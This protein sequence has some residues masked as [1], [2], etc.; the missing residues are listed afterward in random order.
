MSTRHTDQWGQT[1]RAYLETLRSGSLGTNRRGH[2]VAGLLLPRIAN[3]LRLVAVSLAFALPLGVVKGVRD[4]QALRRRGSAVGPL[5]TGLLQGVPDFFLVMLLQIGAAQFFQRTGFRLLPVAW[6]ETRPV[7][8]MVLPVT[9]LALLPLATVA[10]I[11]T[12]AMTNVY[13]QD[14]IRTARAKGLPERVV[15]YKHA[16]AGAL[17]P[18][19]DAMPGVLTVAFSNALIAERLFHYPGVTNLLLDA[20]SPPSLV[21]D[22]R[23][24]LPPPDV[25]VLV[26][27]GAS[28][29][30]IFALLY[31]GVSIL[32]R[33]A[34][35]RL[36]GRDLP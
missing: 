26:A 11:T 27:A 3:T 4:F 5:L 25:P 18:I 9:C 8:S 21:F 13:E 2:D 19:L 22:L 24:P 35:P 7:A 16:L 10:R 17:V 28:L 36:K 1:L 29:G 32:R 6:D 14:Y 15:I 33:V 20:A 31:A 34:D 12:Q 23:R 30:L